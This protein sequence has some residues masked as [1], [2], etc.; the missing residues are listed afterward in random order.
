LEKGTG[1]SEWAG[2]F[3][4]HVTIIK[5]LSHKMVSREFCCH[6]GELIKELRQVRKI[7]LKWF[8]FSKTEN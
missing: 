2:G 7:T 3:P 6:S 1:G 4:V 5:P 8:T